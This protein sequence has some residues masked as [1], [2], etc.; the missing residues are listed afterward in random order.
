MSAGA[1]L[2]RPAGPRSSVAQR[3]ADQPGLVRQLA[4]PPRIAAL[5]ILVLAALLR[6]VRRDLVEFHTDEAGALRRAE[7][8]VRL[9][10]PPLEGAPS[11][12]GVFLEPH[13][14]YLVAPFVAISRDPAVA[15][16]AVAL[17]DVAAVGLTLWLG[18][19]AF[20]PLAGLVAAGL[21]AASPSAVFYARRIWEPD[22]HPLLGVLLFVALDL[23]VLGGRAWW[24]A[25]S[26]PILM[27]GVGVHYIFLLL[28]PFVLL[29]VLAL[30][31]RRQW[32]PLGVGLLAAALLTLPLYFH[33][34][35][36]DFQEYRD[37]RYK[38]TL[39]AAVDLDGLRFVLRA[40]SGWDAPVAEVLPLSDVLPRPLA[41]ALP[42]LALALLLGGVLLALVRLLRPAAP[43]VRLAGLLMWLLVPAALTV[44][45]SADL[46]P[47]YFLMTVPAAF[48]LIGAGAA[49]VVGGA[50][51]VAARRLL[52]MGGAAL[53]AVNCL[54]VGRLLDRVATAPAGCYGAPLPVA[55]QTAA[56][57]VAFAGSSGARQIVFENDE[58]G[59]AS[60]IAYL[61]R[62]NFTS[63]QVPRPD[64][65]GLS[66]P[67][68]PPTTSA[69]AAEPG[70]LTRSAERLDVG[71]TNG[72]RL[73]TAAEA[74]DPWPG[75]RPRLA[76]SW[77]VDA[78][79]A[80]PLQWQADLVDAAGAVVASQAGQRTPPASL[81][82]Q[83]VVSVF[84]FDL[85]PGASAPESRVRLR[86]RGGPTLE[87]VAAG[88][89]LDTWLSRTANPG[90]TPACERSVMP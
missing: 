24:A 73:L 1:R 13:F 60:P 71:Y 55:R 4:T 20:G 44:R 18:W 29:A 85:P 37:F 89:Q 51:R 84:T 26:L 69:A 23:G 62:P 65:A 88:D 45:H 56:D 38:S 33:L 57:L 16:V 14:A 30:A 67:G 41:D 53:V 22:V 68:S 87:P 3:A 79:A 75:W 27:L 12:Q 25:A 39:P 40:P 58:P 81:A 46:H 2:A 28:A 17:A 47:H 78:S 42:D 31:R 80:G 72:V 21:Y 64:L 77:S 52:V 90:T 43:R 32:L 11:S 66:G 54:A 48:L 49:Q 36:T 8:L 76:L 83:P 63:L 19:R 70:A 5:G 61:V 34:R 9:A 86:L 74:N 7:D 82:S 59:D 50:R 35:A 6:L 15:S 10:R